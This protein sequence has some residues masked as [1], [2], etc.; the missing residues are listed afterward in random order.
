[1]LPVVDSE[2]LFSQ[3]SDG[4]GL[5]VRTLAFAR[6]AWCHGMKP[7]IRQLYFANYPRRFKASKTSIVATAIP[8]TH[9]HGGDLRSTTGAGLSATFGLGEEV[10]G[11]TVGDGG[12]AVAGSWGWIAFLTVSI[13]SASRERVSRVAIMPSSIG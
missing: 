2:P 3:L 8:T 1:M 11:T 7:K 6:K 9:G 4:G 12:D 13:F 10:E 5:S